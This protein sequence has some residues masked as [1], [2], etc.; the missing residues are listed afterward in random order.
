MG[1]LD[2]CLV[3]EVCPTSSYRGLTDLPGVGLLQ[4]SSIAIQAKNPFRRR[5]LCVH[6]RIGSPSWGVQVMSVCNGDP[7]SP[8][9]CHSAVVD[10]VFRCKTLVA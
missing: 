1:Y 8:G 2:L 6:I 5:Q 9:R 7:S 10:G 4:L 3:N